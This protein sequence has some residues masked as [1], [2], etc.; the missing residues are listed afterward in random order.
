[1]TPN[2]LKAKKRKHKKNKVFYYKKFSIPMD[3]SYADRDEQLPKK[4]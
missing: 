1:M 4:I 3:R 2:P